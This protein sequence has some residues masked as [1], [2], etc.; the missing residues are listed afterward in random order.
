MQLT[1]HATRGTPHGAS[2]LVLAMSA[3]SAK[4]RRTPSRHG[5]D[6]RVYCHT[7]AA[8]QYNE[9]TPPQKSAIDSAVSPPIDGTCRRHSSTI[10]KELLNVTIV[11][12]IRQCAA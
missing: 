12:A 11:L 6:A 2:R 4:T 8:M 7:T 3:W 10:V 1:L 9:Y 5:T